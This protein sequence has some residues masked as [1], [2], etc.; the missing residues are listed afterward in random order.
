MKYFRIDIENSDSENIYFSTNSDSVVYLDFEEIEE[1]AGS[2]GT[3]SFDGLNGMAVFLK[4][5]NGFCKRNIK[6][7]IDFIL[8]EKKHHAIVLFS[9]N[10]IHPDLIPI[11]DELCNFKSDYVVNPNSKNPIKVWGFYT[12]GIQFYTPSKE[13]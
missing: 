7:I 11:M 6:T 1:V 8:K 13:E 10:N 3:T 4:E 5:N 2:C 12:P 9:T